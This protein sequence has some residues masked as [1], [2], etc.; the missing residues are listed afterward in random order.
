MASPPRG[1]RVP[2]PALPL[3]SDLGCAGAAR[4]RRPG[5]APGLDGEGGGG[6]DRRGD[7]GSDGGE[8]PSRS[9]S[10]RSSPTRPSRSASTAARPGL[11]VGPRRRVLRPHPLGQP[12]RGLRLPPAHPRHLDALSL[13]VRPAGRGPRAGRRRLPGFSRHAL[14]LY[15]R[16]DSGWTRLFWDARVEADADGAL[17]TLGD[18]L[19]AELSGVLAARPSSSST[20]PRCRGSPATPTCSGRPTGWPPRCPRRGLRRPRDAP[21][22]DARLW[23]APERRRHGAAVSPWWRTPWPPGRPGAV[24]HRRTLGRVAAG[25]GRRTA[26]R[27]QARRRRLLRDGA[28]ARCHSGAC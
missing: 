16:D 24:L 5:D 10:A 7:D 9:S 27:C 21:P 3:P 1:R 13:S 23:A 17:R 8:I 4:H 6:G 12:G 19:P 2:A 20:A 18:A 14:D 26:R 25:R 28:C 22:R 15:N 11:R